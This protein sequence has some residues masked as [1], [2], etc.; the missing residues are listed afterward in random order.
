MAVHIKQ[1]YLRHSFCIENPA[2]SLDTCCWNF[3]IEFLLSLHQLCYFVIHQNVF[4]VIPERARAP[5]ASVLHRDSA[6]QWASQRNQPLPFACGPGSSLDPPT[7]IAP[8]LP[9]SSQG[10]GRFVRIVSPSP[11]AHYSNREPRAL[12]SSFLSEFSKTS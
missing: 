9:L 11:R 1:C 6:E 8:L 7:P 4:H 3:A 10:P 2:A 5:T 12:Y